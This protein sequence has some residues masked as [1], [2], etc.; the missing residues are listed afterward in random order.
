VFLKSATCY[1]LS[2]HNYFQ[3]EVDL[4]HEGRCD[5]LK[6]FYFTEV[7]VFSLCD[8]NLKSSCKGGKVLEIYTEINDES[9]MV[10]TPDSQIERIGPSIAD[11]IFLASIQRWVT[12]MG[13]GNAHGV[14]VVIKTPKKKKKKKKVL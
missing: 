11:T 9:M 6:T 5:F 14:V 2:K 12:K 4:E 1:S 3:R 8:G 10:M 13:P 7:C